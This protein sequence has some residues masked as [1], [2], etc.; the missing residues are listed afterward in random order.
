MYF[1]LLGYSHSMI[2]FFLYYLASIVP[3]CSSHHH[4][5]IHRVK[6]PV[7]GHAHARIAAF[8][9]LSKGHGLHPCGT[10][11]EMECS[12]HSAPQAHT[13][14]TLFLSLDYSTH[15]HGIIEIYS[16]IN[17]LTGGGQARP[18]TPTASHSHMRLT[19]SSASCFHPPPA[20]VR[21]CA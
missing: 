2:V 6:I 20:P 19:A 11:F 16:L 8:D 3:V 9:D 4:H 10:H 12:F 14:P 15:P 5:Q 7:I 21:P 18:H 13:V 1:S 17:G